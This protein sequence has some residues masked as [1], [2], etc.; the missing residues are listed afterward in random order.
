MILYRGIVR[1]CHRAFHSLIA[2]VMDGYGISNKLHS[3]GVMLISHYKPVK[4]YPLVTSQ[5]GVFTQM[6][7]G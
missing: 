1:Y 7:D 5:V 2:D 6:Y 3:A 4:I